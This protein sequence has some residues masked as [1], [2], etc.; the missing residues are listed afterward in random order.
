MLR[1]RYRTLPDQTI[2]GVNISLSPRQQA[3]TFTTGSPYAGMYWTPLW[4]DFN[5]T[6]TNGMRDQIDIAHAAGCNC[7]RMIINVTG[8]VFS[9]LYTLAQLY[10]RISTVITYAASLGIASYPATLIHQSN[11]YLSNGGFAAI[12]SNIGQLAG[13]LTQ[14]PSVIA[15]DCAEEF[16]TAQHGGIES[17]TNPSNTYTV[18]PI[19]GEQLQTLMPMV[20]AACRT[21]APA[22]PI[23]FSFSLGTNDSSLW[24]DDEVQTYVALCQP[25]GAD[26]HLYHTPGSGEAQAVYNAAA[27][28]GLP[29]LVGETG[30]GV[31]TTTNPDPQ[32]VHS[33]AVLANVVNASYAG[34]PGCKGA[35]WWEAN[36]DS[37]ANGDTTNDYGLASQQGV[38]R[39]VAA[40]WTAG[41]VPIP[42]QLGQR[43]RR[44]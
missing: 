31:G 11:G 29:F 38:L 2:H 24:S 1:R 27:M 25:D 40:E 30:T 34:H 10:P 35:L 22:L 14:F 5:F 8:G 4:A 16:Q 33:R 20:V 36:Q 6:E 15:M 19:S 44:A 23:L 21:A 28:S 42:F 12:A 7:I 39:P 3:E 26:F 37:T 32:Q 41:A 18:N 17:S 13:F 43:R 9:N